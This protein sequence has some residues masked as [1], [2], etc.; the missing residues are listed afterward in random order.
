MNSYQLTFSITTTINIIVQLNSSL[1]DID[2]NY[3]ESIK[4]WHNTT[5]ITI[6]DGPIFFNI[7]DMHNLLK[8]ALKNK[9]ILNKSITDDIGY[10]YNQYHH[11]TSNLS[12]IQLKNVPSWIGERYRLWQARNNSIKYI[13]WLYND[14]NENIVLEITPF[15]PYFYCNR[16]KEPHYVNYT[17]WIKSYTPYLITTISQK[18]AQEWLEQAE[19]II[20]TVNNNMKRWKKEKHSLFE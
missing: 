5:S 12:L 2:W 15:Y 19:F 1:S 13:T 20:K 6:A 17:Q 3:A 9:L 7:Q 14:L 16:K 18:T 8:K 10:L 11:T 4:L